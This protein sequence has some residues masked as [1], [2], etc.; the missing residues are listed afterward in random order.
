MELAHSEAFAQC[1]VK[2][3]FETVCLHEPTTAADHTQVSSMVT[4]F[5]DSNYNMQ[6]PFVEAAAYC[7]GN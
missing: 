5:K 2:Q 7:R 6:T 1:Q 4:S 3:V